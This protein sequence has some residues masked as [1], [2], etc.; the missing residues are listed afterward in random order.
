MKKLF[1][2]TCLFAVAN[3]VSAKDK[4]KEIKVNPKT[5]YTYCC[6]RSA[7]AGTPGTAGYLS[8]TVTSCLSGSDET[9][10]RFSAC[11]RASDLAKAAV[12]YL[13]EAEYTVTISN[14]S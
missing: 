12:K 3:T 9:L 14:Q 6:A 13:A 11:Q 10:V 7:S 8:V 4:K 5:V 1:I 2:I